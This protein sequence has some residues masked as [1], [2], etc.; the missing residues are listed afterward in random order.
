MAQTETT[1]AMGLKGKSP[2][3]ETHIQEATQQNGNG[4]AVGREDQT[5]PP[6]RDAIKERSLLEPLTAM[7]TDPIGAVC[8]IRV[9]CLEGDIVWA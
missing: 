7:D 4:T 2:E 3:T 9:C 5:D 6:K 1:S 8:W